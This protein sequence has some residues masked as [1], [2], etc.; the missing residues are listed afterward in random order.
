MPTATHPAGLS[1]QLHPRGTVRFLRRLGGAVCGAITGG[2]ARVGGLR[3]PHA[4]RSTHPRSTLRGAASPAAA[5]LPNSDD[6]PFTPEACPGLSPDACA[7]LN[8]PVEDCDPEI[9]RVLLAVLARHI[10]DTMSAELGMD[11]EALFSTLCGRLCAA[12]DEAAPVAPPA[13]EPAAPPPPTS[14]HAVPNAA[15]ARLPRAHGTEPADTA[16]TRDN[17]PHH[18]ASLGVPGFRGRWTPVHARGWFRHGRRSGVD[19][20]QQSCRRVLRGTPRAL[21]PQWRLCYTACAGPP[22]AAARRSR[23]ANLARQ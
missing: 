7:L 19:R 23:C 10:A 18:A 21:P 3:R 4:R 13:T 1:S 12:A 11:A 14:K 16:T 2:I 15:A 22:G 20:R 17:K 5:A 8:T 9:L 6:A